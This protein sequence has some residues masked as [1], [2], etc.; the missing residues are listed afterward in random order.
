MSHYTGRKNFLF[1][2]GLHSWEPWTTKKILKH[3]HPEISH[4]LM[5]VSKDR[6]DLSLW[7]LT[8]L[9]HYPERGPYSVVPGSHCNLE[10]TFHHVQSP[11]R[12]ANWGG[13]PQTPCGKNPH[14]WHQPWPPWHRTSTQ[15]KAMAPTS[16]IWREPERS[17]CWQ[18]APFSPS[19][20][21]LVSLSWPPGTLARKLCPGMR[22][23][24]EP[25]PLG[26]RTPPR[27]LPG[28]LTSAGYWSHG[29]PP[30]SHSDSLC[31]PVSHRSVGHSSSLYCVDTATLCN[32]RAVHWAGVLWWELTWDVL[33]IMAPSPVNPRPGHAWSPLL[34]RSWAGRKGR[35]DRCWK[36]V[37]EREFQLKDCSSSQVHCYVTRSHSLVWRHMCP[38]SVSH[39]GLDHRA[40]LS[41]H[42]SVA[43]TTEGS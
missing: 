33:L 10:G 13:C 1:L 6:N 21:Q 37:T 31:Y 17:F 42:W 26:G 8:A 36:A 35:A 7:K 38:P 5:L 41:G 25:R 15:G 28:A 27:T 11:W 2:K 4:I 18:L 3:S 24:L 30:A 9:L 20:P 32:D 40:R 16:Q 14:T 34:R 12:P 23:A 43:T 19:K 39:G 22:M 29:G